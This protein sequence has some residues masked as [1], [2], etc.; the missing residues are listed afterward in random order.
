MISIDFC[1]LSSPC[2]YLEAKASRSAYKY[3]FDASFDLNSTLTQHGY[4]RFGRYYSKPI[5]ENCNECVSI[6]IDAKNFNFTKSAKKAIKRNKNTLSYI[7]APLC[8]DE[9]L[10]LYSKYH[11]YMSSKK[12]W[13]F[14]ELSYQKYYELYVDGAG[15]FGKEISYYDG[16]KLICVDLIDFINDGISSIY[17]YYDPDYSW[18]SLGKFS[19]LRQIILAKVNNLRWIYLG[20]YVKDCPSLAYKGEYTPFESLK[21]YVEINKECVWE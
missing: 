17:C 15:E 2:P 21:E 11:M 12:D 10:R 18:Y 1:T 3:V 8:D 4:R 13:K 7:S 5:C 9:H 16:E 19:L 6:R 20:F 14:Y